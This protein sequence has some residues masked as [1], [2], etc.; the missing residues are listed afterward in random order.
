MQYKRSDKLSFVERLNPFGFLK[1]LTV[2]GNGK[3]FD[4]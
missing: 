3:L 4:D 2:K 1:E